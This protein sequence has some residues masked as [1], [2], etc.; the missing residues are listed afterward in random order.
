[1]RR[2]R[3]RI[4]SL[5]P[6]RADYAMVRRTWRGDLIAGLT[7]GIVALPLALA[8][9]VSSGAGAEAGLITAIVATPEIAQEAILMQTIISLVYRLL[10]EA[11]SEMAAMWRA[12]DDSPVLAAFLTTTPP[13]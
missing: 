5:L 11:H 13:P 6:R 10:A 3:G 4:M 8:F 2:P 12:D 9:G 1:M 7:V